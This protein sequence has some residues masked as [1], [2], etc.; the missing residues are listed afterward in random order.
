MTIATA[1]TPIV[2]TDRLYTYKVV[3][4]DFSRTY[5]SG[6]NRDQPIVDRW[7]FPA[8]SVLTFDVSRGEASAS[9][10]AHVDWQLNIPVCQVLIHEGT[11]TVELVQSK[12]GTHH[13]CVRIR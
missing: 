9:F 7:Q 5:T 6:A 13:Y 4:V 11:C 3:T 1:T 2:L 10:Q 8:G 12:D